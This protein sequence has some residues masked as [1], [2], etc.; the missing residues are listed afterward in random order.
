MGSNCSSCESTDVATAKVILQ[1]GRLQEF[2]CPIKVSQVLGRNPNCFICNSDDMDFNSLA[3]GIN[4]DEE[5]RPGQLYFSLPMSLSERP[6]MAEEMASL[7][8][9]A[10]LALK[11]SN[12]IRCC[13]SCGMK[14]S[15][16][17]VVYR[18]GNKKVLGS[19][20]VSHDQIVVG[21]GLGGEGGVMITGGSRGVGGGGRGKRR[22]GRGGGRGS[23]TTNLNVI[24]EEQ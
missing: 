10:S 3:L 15:V 8:V 23:L 21:G 13:G 18:T 9:K 17:A 7:A 1:D 12:Q 2:A 20:H 22:G 4:G 11:A 14:R 6:L 5:L 16:D 19:G 24:L